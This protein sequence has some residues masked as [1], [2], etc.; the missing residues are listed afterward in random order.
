MHHHRHRPL[1]SQGVAG[2]QGPLKLYG[3][4][5]VRRIAD[6][7]NEAFALDSEYRVAHHGADFMTYEFGR[8]E[9][10]ERP[11]ESTLEF[12]DLTVAENLKLG[13]PLDRFAAAF[14]GSLDRSHRH[15]GCALLGHNMNDLVATSLQTS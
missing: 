10:I 3:P 1:A 12:G 4:P 15:L 5:G 13:P 8:L 9:P 14:F 6:G 11:V 2:R 7:F